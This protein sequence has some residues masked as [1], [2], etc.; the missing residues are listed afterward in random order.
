MTRW[1]LGLAMALGACGN[2]SA[3]TDARPIDAVPDAAGPP[4]FHPRP[5]AYRNWDIQLHPPFDLSGI[6]SMYMLSLWDL[7]PSTMTMDYGDGDPVTVPAG[8]LA[9]MLAALHA[10]TPIA[11][12]VICVVDTGAWEAARPDA[13]KFP[14]FMA[15]ATMIPDSPTPP[16][17]GSVIGWSVN[18][19][20][21]E[22]FLD[23]LPAH[24]LLWEP[25]IQKRLDLAKAIG[26]D[27]VMGDRNDSVTSQPGPGFTYD[28]SMEAMFQFNWY[29][30]VADQTHMRVMSAGMKDSDEIPSATDFLAPSFD[31]MLMER[32]AEFT[33]CD[34]ARPF[35]N[36]I[37]AV[38]GLE[39]DPDSQGN[40]T[41]AM[42]SCQIEAMGN[43][44]DGLIKDD[45]LSDVE[46]IQCVP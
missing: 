24:V 20:K 23:I 46:R 42:V 31:W 16:A 6:R 13:R 44:Q 17:A 37:E 25:L 35:I 40:P 11:P 45:L 26:C 4:Y 21:T 15:D 5:G 2:S 1:Y 18:G 7:V 28:E 34:P 38:F 22:R 39:Y 30:E 12:I 43:I 3:T 27:G 10:R 8:Q 41:N 19:D 32:C 33:S 9:G 14:G 36:L 29:K